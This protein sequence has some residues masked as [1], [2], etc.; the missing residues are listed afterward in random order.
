MTL[1]GNLKFGKKYFKYVFVRKENGQS[2][3]SEPPSPNPSIW[4][5]FLYEKIK[6]SG[7]SII[8]LRV[9][10]SKF[11]TFLSF[12]K[13]IKKNLGYFESPVIDL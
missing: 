10:Y 4:V 11:H 9:A 8:S 5:L 2:G 3:Y 6:T 1:E 12:A 7:F 13:N